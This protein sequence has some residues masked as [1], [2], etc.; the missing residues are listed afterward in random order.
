[1][2]YAIL[3]LYTL[4]LTACGGGGGGGS[5]TT[6]PPS[7]PPA[8]TYSQTL[9]TTM[10]Y[11]N[12]N[13]VMEVFNTQVAD[14]NGDGLEDVVVS[15]WADDPTSTTQPHS[16]IPLKILI[17]QSNGTLQDQT[18]TLLGAG[19]NAIWGSQRI[20]IADFDGDNKPDIFIGGFQDSPGATY[21][22]V[23]V[24]ST[25]FW[26]NG[27][28]FTRYD[29][30]DLVYGH[31]VCTGILNN[32]NLPSIVMGGGPNIHAANANATVYV[33]NGNRSF[34]LA[35]LQTSISSGGA[36]TVI[37]DA[38]SGNNAI[39]SGAKAFGQAVGYDGVIQI[40]DSNL[41]LVSSLGLPGTED[42]AN[43]SPPLH[44]VDNIINI[45][46]N[47]DGLMDMILTDESSGNSD[48]YFTALINQGNFVFSN[49][50]STYFPT[51]TNNY[52]FQYYTRNFT[53][54]G[55]PTIFVDAT[56]NNINSPNLW[57]LNKGSFSPYLQN[58][59][60]TDIGNYQSPTVYRAGNGNLYLLLIQPNTTNNNC[61]CNFTFYTKPL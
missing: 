40:F 20:I 6:T 28:N 61:P 17:Q 8:Q 4:V 15:G 58:Q 25:I 59:V 32:T 54:N 46:L 45:D 5:N 31:A 16:K 53:L 10:T 50:T 11:Q 34:T 60:S 2:K 23:A 7:S 12:A 9:T 33:N 3:I 41:N 22:E 51:Q 57:Q 39:I 30:T 18:D 13:S 35:N 43:A 14:L 56:D 26:N 19:N 29:F 38:T 47:N 27:T 49:Q 55:L 21:T 52:Y 44:T 1:M 36:C 48:G 42:P 24:S 37:H